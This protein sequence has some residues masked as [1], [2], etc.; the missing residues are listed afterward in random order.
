PTA[1]S[2]DFSTPLTLTTT[3]TTSLGMLIEAS[4]DAFTPSQNPGRWLADIYQL[5]RL[6]L[7]RAGVANISGGECCTFSQSA[8][9]Y[10]Y[11]RDG[12]TGRMA[13]VIWIN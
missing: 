2:T 11:R 7:Q 13:S 1:T 10:S 3:A 6:R 9:F 8:L 12:V 4:A 5:A